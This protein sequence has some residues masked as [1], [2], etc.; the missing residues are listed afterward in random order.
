MR[1]RRWDEALEAVNIP[2]RVAVKSGP[3][4]GFLEVFDTL[5]DMYREYPD[6]SH[7]AEIH[8]VEK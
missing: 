7:Y 2:W 1:L 3:C 8:L 6:E 5:E 4:V